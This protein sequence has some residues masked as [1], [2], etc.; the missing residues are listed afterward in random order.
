MAIVNFYELLLVQNASNY[1]I[2]RKG[3][4]INKP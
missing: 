1:S 4:F 3:V 2:I